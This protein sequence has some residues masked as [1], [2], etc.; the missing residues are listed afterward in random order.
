MLQARV[1]NGVQETDHHIWADYELGIYD[2]CGACTTKKEKLLGK[3]SENINA[4]S[5]TDNLKFWLRQ[6]GRSAETLFLLNQSPAHTCRDTR[7]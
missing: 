2:I 3:G 4:T 7:L 1:K 6:H 5:V